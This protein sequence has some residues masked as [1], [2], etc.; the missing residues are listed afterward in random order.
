MSDR[1]SALRLFA[2]TARVGNFSRA[3]RE[4]GLSQPSASRLIAAIEEEVG[5]TLFSR[6]T[7]AVTLTKA[8]AT[9]LMY[10]K[11]ILAALDEADHEAP[12][13]GELRGPLRIGTSSSFVLREVIP[14][15][16]A[17]MKRHPALKIEL[18]SNHR[19]RDLVTEG[20]DV[21]FRF[22]ALPDSSATA[23]KII[24]LPRIL[25]A[26]PD[27]L[28]ERDT[29][30]NAVGPRAPLGD[31][32]SGAPLADFLLPRG[33]HGHRDEPELGDGGRQPDLVE[34]DD[35]AA[36][37]SHRGHRL[38]LGEQLRAP[39]SGRAHARLVSILRST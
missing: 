18:V 12:G 21:A 36:V 32:R 17:F 3:G 37:D 38:P 5:P 9:Y 14:Q 27:Y 10:V 30:A 4:L 24:H 6:T 1:L 19:Y 29:P 8:G 33:A 25:M 7:Q 39:E 16:P 13:T 35:R 28:G 11:P 34:G 15:L 20:I 23:L 22:G 2:R 26:S 31:H